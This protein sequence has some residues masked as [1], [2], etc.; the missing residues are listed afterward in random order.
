M[1]PIYADYRMFG[2]IEEVGIAAGIFGAK[3]LVDTDL[4]LAIGHLGL[5]NPE[6]IGLVSGSN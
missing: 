4:I 2:L 5:V 6:P 1:Q 3:F